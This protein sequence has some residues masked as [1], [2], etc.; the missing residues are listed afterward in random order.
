MKRLLIIGCGDVVRRALPQLLRRW[1]V[2]ALVRQRDPA[3][4]ALGVTQ[5]RGD[6]DCPATLTRLG[7]IAHA[8]LHSAPPPER[9]ELDTRTRQLIAALRRRE[10]L[11]RRLTYIS[12]SGV[13]GD[14]GGAH[15]DETRTPAPTTA[16]AR[17]RVDAERCLRR[18]GRQSGCRV[19]ILRAPG[20]YAADR[21]PLERLRK[22]LPLLRTDEDVYTNHIHA[23]DL[24]QICVAALRRAPTQRVYNAVDDASLPAG[25]WFDKLADAFDLPRAPRVAR[26]EL[27]KVLSPLQLSF[28]AESRRLDN[29]R[30][31]RELLPTLRYP[32]VDAG[33]AA[34]KSGGK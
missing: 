34:A 17:R 26:A 21:M 23:D 6:L 13:Y 32:T 5:L 24:A 31:K 16:R 11:P 8:V 19:S 10:S 1:R 20:I 3:L 30:L 14:C 29:A 12:T 27:E 33:I 4:A 2:Y 9:G 28:M 15:V 18:F 25:V 22:G 7:G